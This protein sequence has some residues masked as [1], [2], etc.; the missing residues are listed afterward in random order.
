MSSTLS[1]TRTNRLRVLRVIKGDR[2]SGL[3]DESGG[4][5]GLHRA[6]L[7]IARIDAGQGYVAGL[8]AQ[9]AALKEVAALLRRALRRA[10]AKGR[11]ASGGH[12]EQAH[13]NADGRVAVAAMVAP[14]LT[15]KL[16][17]PRREQQ[18]LKRYALALPLSRPLASG[19]HRTVPTN[20]G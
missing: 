8:E 10:R 5:V 17:R 6:H 3:K 20:A 1:V 12:R 2:A 19:L 16:V 11:V 7:A 18:L 15:T 9:I 14:P 4:H 13:R